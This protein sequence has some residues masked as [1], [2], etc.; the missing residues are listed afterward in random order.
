MDEQ[1]EEDVLERLDHLEHRHR[2]LKGAVVAALIVLL[3]LGGGAALAARELIASGRVRFSEDRTPRYQI[4]PG[5]PDRV[6]RLDTVTG[7]V[8]AFVVA[9]TESGD[10]GQRLNL[11]LVEV[12]SAPPGATGGGQ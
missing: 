7:E 10:A 3:I 5:Q 11:K 8:R 6:F 1:L 9:N 4:A 12:P 2:R